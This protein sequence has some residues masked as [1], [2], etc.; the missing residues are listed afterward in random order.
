MTSRLCRGTIH[1]A[2]FALGTDYLLG[3]NRPVQNIAHFLN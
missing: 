3:V 2:L 1:R